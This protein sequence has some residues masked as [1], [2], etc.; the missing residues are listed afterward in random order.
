M[1][2]RSLSPAPRAPPSCPHIKPHSGGCNWNPSGSFQTFSLVSPQGKS[3]D[4]YRS[5]PRDAG[6]WNSHREFQRETAR[7]SLSANH[8]MVDRWLERQEQVGRRPPGRRV[9]ARDV[10][11]SLSQA[12][13]TLT[14]LH[15]HLT[16]EIYSLTPPPHPVQTAPAPPPH[17]PGRMKAPLLEFRGPHAGGSARAA[18]SR[19]GWRRHQMWHRTG[20]CWVPH[21]DNWFGF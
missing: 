14:Y 1:D 8:P 21:L 5:L 3:V 19:R 13:R 17:P 15:D 6:T 7:S 11:V 16:L 20:S 4:T 10:S 18:A 2:S 12:C 9:V